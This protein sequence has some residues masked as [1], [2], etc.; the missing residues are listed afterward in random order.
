[1]DMKSKI[2]NKKPATKKS[3]SEDDEIVSKKSSSKSAD[4]DDDADEVEDD[5]EKTEDDDY[6]PDFEEFDIPKS[7][8]KAGPS[9]KGKGDEDDLGLDDDFKTLDLFDDGAGLDDEEEE[10]F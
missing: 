6:D 1:M 7:K 3:F 4:D 8:I 5:W 9:K 10:D 2:A